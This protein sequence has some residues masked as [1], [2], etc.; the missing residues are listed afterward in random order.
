MRP[1]APVNGA[2]LG[3]DPRGAKAFCRQTTDGLSPWRCYEASIA[4]L[5]FRA[6]G[7]FAG[8]ET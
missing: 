1:E 8:Q 5:T 3:L 7:R 2:R 6:S 4:K